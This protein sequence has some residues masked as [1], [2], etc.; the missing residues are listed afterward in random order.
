MEFYGG[1]Q[2]GKKNKWS[3][4]GGYPDHHADSPVGNSA[5]TQQIM[6]GFWWKFQDSSAMI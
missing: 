1:L 3:N 5:I 6:S 2:G 4:F